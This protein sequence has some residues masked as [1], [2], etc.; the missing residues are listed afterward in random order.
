MPRQRGRPLRRE[1]N[2]LSIRPVTLAPVS[3]PKPRRPVCTS[4]V[5]CDHAVVHADRIDMLGAFNGKAVARF[6]TA[7]SVAV[8][9]SITDG[10]GEYE[11]ELSVEHDEA[12]ATLGRATQRVNLRKPTTYHDEET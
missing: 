2:E 3:T 10:Q 7:L 1:I 6:P 5:V 8:V 11:L 12:E 9:F 4:I